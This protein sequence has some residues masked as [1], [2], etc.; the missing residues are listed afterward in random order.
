[1]PEVIDELLVRLGVDVD[2]RAFDQAN[3]QFSALTGRITRFAGVVGGL[4]VAGAGVAGILG[5]IAAS[6]AKATQSISELATRT[7]Q[8][9]EQVSRLQSTFRNITG[10]GDT[11]QIDSFMTK[12]SDWRNKLN[13]QNAPYS[14]LAMAGFD[15]LKIQQ[16]GSVRESILEMSR[17]Y[18]DM[19]PQQRQIAQSSGLYGPQIDQLL[20]PGP[21]AINEGYNNAQNVTTDEQVRNSQEF[22]RQLQT[23]QQNLETF[24]TTLG[25]ISVGPFADIL[26]QINGFL[27]NNS[28]KIYSGLHQI[29]DPESGTRKAID[30]GWKYWSPFGLYSD[31]HQGYEKD[32]AR[33]AAK[34]L[35]GHNPL[36]AA[37][38]AL[39]R[40]G[41]PDGAQE[42]LESN[43]KRQ[44]GALGPSG[45]PQNL[46]RYFNRSSLRNNV[47][48][49]ALYALAAQ[50]SSFNPNA[51]GQQTKYGKAQGLM[52]YL[53]GVAKKLGFD[54]RNPEQSIEAAAKQL[55][56][57]LDKG[58]S[59]EHALGL[60]YA[61]TDSKYGPKSEAYASQVRARMEDYQRPSMVAGGSGGNGGGGGAQ[62]NVHID[63][64]NSHDPAAT[65]AAVEEGIN[66]MLTNASVI[67]SINFPDDSTAA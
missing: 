14:D 31:V 33:G 8:S 51:V 19:S 65:Q 10:V 2:N 21:D 1:M 28:E 43:R 32:G 54:P 15:A 35:F 50:E 7:G 36:F 26:N 3:V 38:K 52:Q 9:V 58:Y 27:R 61:G 25:Q 46:L 41:Q 24:G 47:P 34:S 57:R 53:P 17:E 20:N 29:S 4:T 66:R 37:A 62:T 11:S 56:E 44:E 39:S 60:H 5:G 55:R 30:F 49:E 22:N 67:T 64:R 18:Q 13:A 16:Q 45:I 42:L 40:D 12:V 59:I 23:A 48:K 6:S 63:A